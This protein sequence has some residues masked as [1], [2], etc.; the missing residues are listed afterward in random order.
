MGTSASDI[1][2]KLPMRQ[3]AN[4]NLWK[5]IIV[6]CWLIGWLIDCCFWRRLRKIWRKVTVARYS[7]PQ[8]GKTA[9][10]KRQD[11]LIHDSIEGRPH[12][13]EEEEIKEWHCEEK[14]RLFSLGSFRGRGRS[15]A[16]RTTYHNSTYISCSRLDQHPNSIARS[17]FCFVEDNDVVGV[18]ALILNMMRCCVASF[19]VWAVAFCRA[20]SKNRGVL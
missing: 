16:H 6:I 15:M 1:K 3:I 10:I 18:F 17:V 4:K 8:E 20:T 9:V 14:I 12:E 11:R 13:R 5:E 7:E 19:F 2:A